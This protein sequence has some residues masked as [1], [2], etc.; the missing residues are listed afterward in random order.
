MDGHQIS[1]TDPTVQSSGRKRLALWCRRSA[2][3]CRIM[4]ST[5]LD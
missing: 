4:G 2:L 5:V 3:S 1:A